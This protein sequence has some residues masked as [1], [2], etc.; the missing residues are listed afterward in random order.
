MT[1][2]R[3]DDAGSSILE[4]YQSGFDGKQA[5]WSGWEDPT[6]YKILLI[7]DLSY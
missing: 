6:P 1:A 2:S 3:T 5:A 7:N 4:N